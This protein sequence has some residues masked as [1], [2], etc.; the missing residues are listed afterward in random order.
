MSLEEV[1]KL[2]PTEVNL[3]N[4]KIFDLL[5]LDVIIYLIADVAF[6]FSFQSL[7]DTFL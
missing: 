2:F 3:L 1:H 7:T 6:K 5:S 4:G